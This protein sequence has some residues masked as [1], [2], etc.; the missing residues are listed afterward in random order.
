MH[1]KDL[2]IISLRHRGHGRGF[3]EHSHVNVGGAA[4]I[5]MFSPEIDELIRKKAVNIHRQRRGSC[6]FPSFKQSFYEVPQGERGPSSDETK[7]PCLLRRNSTVIGTYMANL[8]AIS[9]AGCR[10]LDLRWSKGFCTGIMFIGYQRFARADYALLPCAHS[11]DRRFKLER[12]MKTQWLGLSIR[13][14]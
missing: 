4:T 10:T 8:W 9:S 1:S 7:T 13:A 12:T 14:N 5:S 11:S 6:G 2:I 3:Q